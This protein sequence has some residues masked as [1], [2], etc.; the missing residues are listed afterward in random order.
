VRVEP[1]GGFAGGGF[2][3]WPWVWTFRRKKGV[4]F[5][6]RRVR[7]S[8]R[9]KR[10]F[11][12]V[13]DIERAAIRGERKAAWRTEGARRNMLRGLEAGEDRSEISSYGWSGMAR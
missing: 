9:R 13:V 11:W 12:E 5:A 3:L 6:R 2:A 8:D 10:V 1:R 7:D 4:G